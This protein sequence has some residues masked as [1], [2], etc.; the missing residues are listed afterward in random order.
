MALLDWV[1]G[2]R[3]S[4]PLITWY[5]NGTTTPEVL[6]GATITATIAAGLGSSRVVRA[7]TGTFTVTNGAGGVFRWDL[8]AA[9]VADE[10]DLEVQFTADFASGQTPAITFVTKWTVGR[11]NVVV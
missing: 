5:Q 6:T 2:A 3:Y 11:R 8:S 4:S 1:Q 7:A 9:D 10:G